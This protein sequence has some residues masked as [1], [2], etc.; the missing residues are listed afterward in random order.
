M[1]LIYQS[2]A[3][4]L[5]LCTV[6]NSKLCNLIFNVK[7]SATD[8]LHQFK[9][10]HENKSFSQCGKGCLQLVNILNF[11]KQVLLF[12]PLIM[13]ANLIKNV[14]SSNVQNFKIIQIIYKQDAVSDISLTGQ[15]P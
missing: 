6:F 3:P 9:V 13:N 10:T 7:H 15:G 14:Y 11:A 2:L 5:K 4:V 12:R 1:H 8:S